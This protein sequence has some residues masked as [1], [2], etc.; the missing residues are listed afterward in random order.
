MRFA[1]VNVDKI[2]DFGLYN[3][4]YGGTTPAIGFIDAANALRQVITGAITEEDLR[5]RLETLAA[6]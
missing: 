3:R 6:P 1:Y 5:A 2:N 4:I